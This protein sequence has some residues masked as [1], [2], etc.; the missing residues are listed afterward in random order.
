MWARIW[1]NCAKMK[2]FLK[3]IFGICMM[4]SLWPQAFAQES[5]VPAK[6]SFKLVLKHEFS[7]RE[8]DLARHPEFFKRTKKYF[9][10]EQEFV[11]F[12]PNFCPAQKVASSEQLLEFTFGNMFAQEGWEI[13]TL[14][15]EKFLR[16]NV[17]PDFL[18]QPQDVGIFH[19]E[20]GQVQFDGAA[21]FGTRLNV[22]ESAKLIR[23]AILKDLQVVNLLVEKIPPQVLPS[24]TLAAM[25]IAD[26]LAVGVSDFQGSPAN[27]VHNIK[28]GAANFNGFIFKQ[29]EVFNFNETLGQVGPQTGFLP[30]LVI[31]GAH[32]VPEFGG[33]LCQVSTTAFRAALLAGLE[34]VERWSHAY[35]VDYYQPFGTDATI[36]L[37]GKNLRFK[38]NTQ[39]SVLMQTRIVGNK[40]FFHFYGKGDEREVAIMGPKLWNFQNAPAAQI[41]SSSELQPGQVKILSGIHGGLN[42]L[43]FQHVRKDGLESWKEIFSE[44]EPRGLIKMIG[45]AS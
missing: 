45:A 32:T 26:L 30:E 24:E 22:L 41:I 39:G 28:V 3:I 40:L 23:K 7:T 36:Y 5:A 43:W 27:R 16:E 8:L 14:Q 21:T 11:P 33:G 12:E 10:L 34:I 31:K 13:D 4:V 37:G 42:S 20:N 44:F 9:L 1:Q 38:N 2:S 6:F 25:G 17:A 19:D 18:A 15:I 29:D 35:S